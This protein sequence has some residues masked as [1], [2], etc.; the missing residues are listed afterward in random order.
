MKSFVIW[1]IGVLGQVGLR[2]VTG[3]GMA[4]CKDFAAMTTAIL[5][6][7]GHKAWMVLVHREEKYLAYSQQIPALAEF[8]HAIVKVVAKNGKTYC[9]DP[10]NLSVW[11]MVFFPILQIGWPLSSTPTTRFAKEFRLSIQI[12]Q[13]LH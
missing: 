11:P 9:V 8:N 3:N 2:P 13:K 12:M 7:L 6:T 10:T 5:R 4:D 1:E